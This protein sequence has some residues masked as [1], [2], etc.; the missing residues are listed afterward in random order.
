MEAGATTDTGMTATRP[1][2]NCFGKPAVGR[3]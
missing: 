2:L 3:P 1:T